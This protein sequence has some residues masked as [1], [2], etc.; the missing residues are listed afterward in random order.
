MQTQPYRIQ[1]AAVIGAGVMGAAIAAQLALNLALGFGQLLQQVRRNG[2]Q[3][4]AGQFQD[5]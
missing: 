5:L 2:Q 3:V 1:K 4:A